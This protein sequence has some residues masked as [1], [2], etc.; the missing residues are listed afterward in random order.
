MPARRIIAPPFVRV[1]RRQDNRRQRAQLDRTGQAHHQPGDLAE[2][3]GYAVGS[4]CRGKAFADCHV[5][6]GLPV[7]ECLLS[8][9]E[10]SQARVADW[11]HSPSSIRFCPAA[12]RAPES[13]VSRGCSPL[14]PPCP[15]PLSRSQFQLRL[16][17]L[18]RRRKPT[19]E[20]ALSREISKRRLLF[21]LAGHRQYPRHLRLDSGAR[22]F[23]DARFPELAGAPGAIRAPPFHPTPR[24]ELENGPRSQ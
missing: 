17:R 24:P 22:N 4:G 7:I 5:W 12:H 18:T 15:A 20:T 2:V 16:R 6:M 11:L 8:G 14:L 21:G 1:K 3:L 23:L 10:K 13:G 19:T 9:W